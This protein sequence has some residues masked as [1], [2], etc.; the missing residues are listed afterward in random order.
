MLVVREA[1]P[2]DS[3]DNLIRNEPDSLQKETISDK[4]ND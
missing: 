2:I 4:R 3:A 1:K